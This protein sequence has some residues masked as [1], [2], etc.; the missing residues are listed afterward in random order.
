MKLAVFV[1]TLIASLSSLEGILAAPA[2]KGKNPPHGTWHRKTNTKQ[3]E[4]K[5]SSGN[6][7]TLIKGGTPSFAGAVYTFTPDFS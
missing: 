3:N 2:S 1:V 5:K 7:S 4:Y 6:R